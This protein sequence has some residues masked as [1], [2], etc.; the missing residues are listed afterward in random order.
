MTCNSIPAAGVAVFIPTL[1]S[2]E[3]DPLLKFIV[4]GVI[5]V[6]LTLKKLCEAS[7]IGSKPP[8]A[9]LLKVS[10]GT[11][12]PIVTSPEKVAVVPVVWVKLASTVTS[13]LK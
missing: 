10:V 13:P 9:K 8:P 5:L 6:V 3:D 11:V 12:L 4:N 7:N 1:P 2:N